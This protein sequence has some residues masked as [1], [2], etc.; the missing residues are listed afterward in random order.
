MTQFIHRTYEVIP[1]TPESQMGIGWNDAD[2][3][4]VIDPY[5]PSIESQFY[6][7]LVEGNREYWEYFRNNPDVPLNDWEH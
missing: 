1:E 2:S 3:Q 5:V 6:R 7:R 4:P